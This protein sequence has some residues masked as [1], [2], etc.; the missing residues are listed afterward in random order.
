ME[1]GENMTTMNCMNRAGNHLLKHFA[2]LLLLALAATAAAAQSPVEVVEQAADEL[3]KKLDGR[4]DALREDR[5]ALYAL[6]DEI[7]LPRFDR[8]YSAQLVLGR[9]WRQASQQQRQRFI[10]AF[11]RSLLHRYA[12][13]VLDYDE[14]KVEVLPY[15]GN[16]DDKRTMVRTFVTLDDGTRVPVNYALVKRDSGWLMFDVNIEGI[17]YVRNFRAEMDAEIREK[18]LDAVIKRLESEAAIKDSA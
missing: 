8:N 7:L 17:S 10:D 1:Y 9:H 12:D 2:A 4:K 18:G 14:E 13:G 11:Y 15:R 3:S 6:I 5:Q 16:P